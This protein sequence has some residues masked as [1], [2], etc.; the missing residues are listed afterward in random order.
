VDSS[1]LRRDSAGC[2]R[3]CTLGFRAGQSL[4]P[5]EPPEN[6]PVYVFD[7]RSSVRAVAAVA[8]AVAVLND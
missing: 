6:V 1:T 5:W 8:V 4:H 3:L 2:C 7:E